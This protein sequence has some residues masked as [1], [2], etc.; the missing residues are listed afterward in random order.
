MTSE[1]SAALYSAPYS[2]ARRP[3]VLAVLE[4]AAAVDPERLAGGIKVAFCREDGR[5]CVR[6]KVMSD[7]LCLPEPLDMWKKDELCLWR[8]PVRTRKVL[9]VEQ[10]PEQQLSCFQVV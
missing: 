10:D 7:V 6:K 1:N 3:Y 2:T 5:V 8:L 4:R 9:E